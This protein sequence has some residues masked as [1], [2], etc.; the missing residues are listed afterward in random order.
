MRS[1]H[2][3]DKAKYHYETVETYELSEEHAS[4]FTVFFLR[5]LIERDLINA[6]FVENSEAHLARFRA[7]DIGI[8]KIYDLWDR[9]LLDD[10]LSDEGNE[11]AMHYF[12]FEKGAYLQDYVDLLQGSLPTEFHI[13]YNEENYQRMKQVIDRN[14]E[15]W[16]SSKKQ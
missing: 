12:G 16:K 13:D 1:P 8:H 3:Y 10:M 6:F 9:C 5:W 4:N 15:K 2:V 14:Y 11:F 7:G